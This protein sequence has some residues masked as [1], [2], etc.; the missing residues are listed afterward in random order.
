MG[1]GFGKGEVVP[2]EATGWSCDE[3]EAA[4]LEDAWLED[5]KA[6][7]DAWAGLLGSGEAWAGPLGSCGDEVIESN[8][9]VAWG[10]IDVIKRKDK[11]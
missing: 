11:G 5:G 8:E 9:D 4:W 1:E 6:V 7:V 2:E 10:P 3:G